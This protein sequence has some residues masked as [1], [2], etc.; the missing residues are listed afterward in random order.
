MTLTPLT[1]AERRR[2][3]GQA[4][5]LKALLK[6]GKQ[7]LTPALTSSIIQTFAHHPLL[8]IRLDDFKEER[9]ELGPKLAEATGSHLVTVIGSVIVLYRPPPADAAK[10]D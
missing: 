1:A 3:K 9:K 7:G 6:L 5:K 8:K 10:P 2:L 4:Q